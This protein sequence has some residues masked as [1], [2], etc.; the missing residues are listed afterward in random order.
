LEKIILIAVGWVYKLGLRIF[1]DDSL[2]K[3]G[4]EE[5]KTMKKVL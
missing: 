1:S 5:R 4:G 3:Y 2:L